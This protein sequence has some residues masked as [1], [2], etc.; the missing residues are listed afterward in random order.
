MLGY[1]CSGA[2]SSG[3]GYEGG[4]IKVTA[5]P[6]Q[7]PAVVMLP[8]DAEEDEMKYRRLGT[9]GLRVS[10]LGLGCNTFGRFAD[11]D[12]TARIVH[13]ALDQGVNFFDTADI[14]SAGTSEEFLG[15]ALAGR[16]HQA[17]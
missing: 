2:Y 15:R 6:H 7:A 17:G 16:R 14:Y 4:R 13:T 9:S 11:A 1:A 10:V 12:Q 3:A 5:G 8:G